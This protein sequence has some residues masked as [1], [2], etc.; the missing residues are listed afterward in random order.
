MQL[1]A[2]VADVDELSNNSKGIVEL[3]LKQQLSQ[4]MVQE[5]VGIYDEYLEVHHKISKKKE[6]KKKRTSLNSVKVLKIC[7]QI[8]VELTQKQKVVVLI[9]LIEYVN[10]DQ[11]INEQEL[12]FITT[13]GE[14][15]NI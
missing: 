5:Y 7:T 10:S 6:G 12:E 15:F 8:N 1:F 4:D 3:F 14:S 11:T 9:R 2:L 13:V